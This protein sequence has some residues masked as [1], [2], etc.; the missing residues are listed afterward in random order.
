MSIRQ[1]ETDLPRVSEGAVCPHDGVALEAV[2]HRPAPEGGA[3]APP[4]VE[5]LAVHR[6]AVGVVAL[7][8]VPVVPVGR[9]PAGPHAAGPCSHVTVAVDPSLRSL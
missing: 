1:R 9:A 6:A 4:E 8:R 5:A 7:V 2:R 3:V